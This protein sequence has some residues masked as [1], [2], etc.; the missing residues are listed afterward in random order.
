MKISKQARIDAKHLFRSC[1]NNGLLEEERVRRAVQALVTQ[2]P[3]GYVAILAH[4]QRLV[5]LELL[6]RS[7]RVES[8]AGLSESE[9]AA[10]KSSLAQKYGAGLDFTFAQNPA[11]IGGL[12]IQVGSDVF[13]GSVQARLT[14]LR[15][16]F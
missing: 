5:K 7:A 9:Q 11:L 3:R 14:A 13:D 2:K 6:R 16:S 8:A 4:L 1:L 10:V 15:E 12:R